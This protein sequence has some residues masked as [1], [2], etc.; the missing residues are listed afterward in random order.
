M[1]LPVV[2]CHHRDEVP[3]SLC[4]RLSVANGFSSKR[5]FMSM[6]GI[7]GAALAKG[8]PGAIDR[9][10]HWSGE[11]A[12]YLGRNGIMTCTRRRDWRLGGAV[13]NNQARCGRRFRYCPNCVLDDIATGR[14]RPVSRPYVRSAWLSRT[15]T[16]CVRHA[17]P[18]VEVAIA[19]K[20][21]DSFCRFV[22]ANRVQ[23][24]QEAGYEASVKFLAVDAYAHDRIQWNLREPHLDRFETH[25]AIDLCLHLGQFLRRHRSALSLIPANLH[26]APSREIGFYYARQGEAAIRDIVVAAIKKILPNGMHKFFFGSLGRWLRSNCKHAEF[27]ELVELFQDIAER[28]LPFGISDM[29]FVPVRK[30]YLHSVV[31]AGIEYGLH[32]ERIVQLMQEGGL[33]EN[34]S[35]SRGRIYFDAINAHEI[36]GAA[37]KTLTSRE[38]RSELGV[39]EGVMTGL[40][41]RGLLA[42]VEP[43]NGTRVYSRIR[44]EDLD[45]LRR[46]I[47]AYVTVGE[48]DKS[49]IPITRVCQNSGCEI[50][51]VLAALVGGHLTKVFIAPNDE[52]N[53][54]SLRFDREEALGHLSKERP[55]LSAR[56]GLAVMNQREASAYMGVKPT[57]IPY[58][59]NLGLLDTVQI[60]N[61]VNNRLQLAVTVK[62]MDLFRRDHILVSEVAARHETHPNTILDLF[63]KIGVRPIYD[64]CGNV[65]RFFLRSDVADAPIQVRRYKRK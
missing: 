25:V 5:V 51:D 50:G 14:G 29:C 13:F 57:T 28:N 52:R 26:N 30:R 22:E 42:R 62:S 31:S 2:V 58:L 33:I 60:N 20:T 10:A 55:T 9:L 40:L 4:D 48:V 35:L 27:A 32:E 46:N 17:R 21:D 11:D 54:S 8:E 59:I 18:I 34:P 53:I 1:P 61:P 49:V 7:K 65:S 63:A 37:S 23:I 39:T 47:F 43:R 12:T 6:T 16:N 19:S 41:E 36:L 44:R 15:I 3:E 45:K 64:N 38:A 24:E 56:A